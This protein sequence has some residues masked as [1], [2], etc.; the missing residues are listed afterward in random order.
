MRWGHFGLL[1]LIALGAFACGDDA[2]DA[3]SSEPFTVV[4]FNTGT[5]PAIARNNTPDM[6]YTAVEADLSDQYYGDGLAWTE[7]IDAVQSF[8][9]ATSPD[10]IAFQEI[11][12]P[13]ECPSIP[14]TAYPGF[15]CETWQPGDPTVAQMVLGP[16]YVVATH[17]G[18]TDKCLAVKKSFGRIVGCTED[19]CPDGLDGF[20]VP[21]CGSGSRVGR[22]V[23]E[24]PSGER[25]TVVSYHGTSG[26]SGDDVDCRLRQIDQ[27]FV[28]FGDGQPAANGT[29]NLILGDFNT[30]PG[31]AFNID[32]SA[33][34]WQDFVGA[35][36]PFHFISAVGFDAPGSYGGVLDIDHII[37]DT[38]DGNVTYPG[39]TAG[40]QDVWSIPYF[41][42][43]PVVGVVSRSE[44]VSR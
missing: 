30:D 7:A 42:H 4:T 28:D 33:A 21:G 40:T 13:N 15:V 38:F 39:I 29:V 1:L 32:P 5:T 27:I 6:G 19:Y 2:E 22:A 24:R 26:L 9:A 20:E 31:R 8:L 44:R 41:D 17:L 10:I 12:D 18:K 43:R 36:L 23:I 3:D 34:R 25:I 35:G 37:S 16:D 14:P 11:F